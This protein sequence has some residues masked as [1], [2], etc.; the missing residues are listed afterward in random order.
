LHESKGN[1]F[2]AD[3]HE[4]DENV[5]KLL[6]RHIRDSNKRVQNPSLLLNDPTELGMFGELSEDQRHITMPFED[7][8]R[9]VTTMRIA[10]LILNERI[11]NKQKAK[12]ELLSRRNIPSNR[13]ELSMSKH[14]ILKG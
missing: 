8:H 1:Y 3:S 14:M 4:T 6:T 2:P 5:E 10:E 13:L 7:V 11:Q 12:L 9:L